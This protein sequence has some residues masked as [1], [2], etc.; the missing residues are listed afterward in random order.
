MAN[1]E[2]DSI[3][4]QPSQIWIVIN[5]CRNASIEHATTRCNERFDPSQSAEIVGCR[6]EVREISLTTRLKHNCSLQLEASN[7]QL[8]LMAK[9]LEKE[10]T[11]TDQVNS[12]L[13]Q[14]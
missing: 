12:E 9:D 6:D 13:D 5:N 10:K 2:N 3:S 14:R 11:K 8:E 1:K 7:E 4:L